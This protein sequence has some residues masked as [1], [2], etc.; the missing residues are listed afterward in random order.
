MEKLVKKEQ[1]YINCEVKNL[2]TGKLYTYLMK[3]PKCE[4]EGI[5]L[6]NTTNKP[7]RFYIPLLLNSN[8]LVGEYKNED[9]VKEML[10]MINSDIKKYEERIKYLK[11]KKEKYTN[12]IT[13]KQK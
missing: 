5:F 10:N 1:L 2:I 9:Y 3:H 11:K 7:I 8:Y 13:N 6:D 12:W 4:S